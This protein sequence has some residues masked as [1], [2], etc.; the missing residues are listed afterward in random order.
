MRMTILASLSLLAA[1]PALAQTAEPETHPFEG[2]TITITVQSPSG[3]Q[4]L[5][6]VNVDAG[7]PPGGYVACP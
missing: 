6:T 2:G 5:F 3:L 4:T 7:A 1:M